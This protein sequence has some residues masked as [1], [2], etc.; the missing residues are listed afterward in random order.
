MRLGAVAVPSLLLAATLH[1]QDCPAIAPVLPNAAPS[2]ALDATNCQ[3]TDGSAYMPYRLDLAT[4]GQIQIDLSGAKANLALILRDASG[5]RIDS[6]TSIHRSIEAGSYVV[7][8]NG[9]TASDLGPYTV[10][11]AFSAEPGMM[12]ANFPNI[13]GSQTVAGI[14][15]GSGCLAPDSSPYEAYTLTTDG[16]GTLTITITSQDFTPIV[17]LRSGDG[18][19]LNSSA[20]GTVTALV[21]GDSQYQVVVSSADKTGNYQIATAFQ[22]AADET[23]RSQAT[24]TDST[25]ASGAI[26]AGSC[27][28]TSQGSGD[29]LYYN[30]YGVSLPSAG[31]ANFTAVSPDFTATLN[32]LDAAGNVLASDS[33]GDGFDSA[34]NAQSN[35]RLQLPA[36]AYRLQVLS[37]VPSGGN[38]SLQYA[39]T[40]GNP[41]PCMPTPASPGDTLSGALSGSS[42]RTALGLAD[43]YTMTLPA[44]GTLDLDLSSFDFSTVLAM[45]DSKDNLIVQDD[46]VDGATAA[47]ISADLPAG[48][49]TI[50]AG[51]S[52]A[53]GKYIATAKLTPHDIAAC[54]YVQTLDLNGGYIQRLGANS[55]R[56]SNG[57]PVD[58]YSFTTGV[59]S[60]VLAVMT[61]SEVD[62]HLTLLDSHGTVLRRD[63]NSYGPGDPLIVQF[64]PAGTYTLAAREA[65]AGPGGLYE[66]DLRTVAGSRP[67]FCTPVGSIASGG[68]V[69]GN[70]TYTACQYTDGSFADMYTFNLAADGPVDLRLSSS[71]FDAYLILLDAKGNVVDVDDDSGGGTNARIVDT[72][73]AGTYYVVAKPLGDYTQHG[74]YTLTAAQTGN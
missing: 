30:Y 2:G 13:G 3:L 39:F 5:T 66:V 61:S 70:I 34:G 4:R 36:G 37:D 47:H 18:R 69:S 57:Q 23:C 19:L 50:V 41:Q 8:V 51:A 10:T 27:Y 71:D 12:C 24:L 68:T 64:L 63:E 62:G 33:G 58:Y 53:A 56:G 16:S 38:Y 25:S 9:Q 21:S 52:T 54:T 15:G 74:A 49:Y 6:G 17:T 59:D 43:L 55:C 46:N 44:A 40:A 42:C 20:S 14:L 22:S 73:P 35:V 32:L 48:A 29:Q 28:V 65:T 67:P 72:L 11:T 26:S 7:L 1:A 31:V 60:L 45:R